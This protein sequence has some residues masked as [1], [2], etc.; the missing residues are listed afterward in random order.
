MIISDV[1]LRQINI[2][3]PLL[4]Y[5]SLYWA[6]EWILHFNSFYNFNNKDFYWKTPLR[7]NWDKYDISW[8]YKIKIVLPSM[9]WDFYKLY[10][11]WWYLIKVANFY[12][13]NISDLHV[14]IIYWKFA[15]CCVCP[16]LE[17]IELIEKNL[18][19]FEYITNYVIP[20]LYLQK[21][22]E[23][24]DQKWIWG[25]YSHDDKWLYEELK[26]KIW[27]DIDEKYLKTIL[28]KG[29]VNK[30]QPC[31]CWSWIGFKK[32]HNSIF[33]LLKQHLTYFVFP[34]FS[35][36]NPFSTSNTLP[37]AS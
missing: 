30:K 25:E 18:S 28:S 8:S 2:E 15:D 12:N 17:R 4:K 23:I 24:F 1:D 35:P 7:F 9:K 34:S 20:F 37:Q 21:W 32:C 3:F 29:D 11:I 6:L 19:I 27:C 13:K 31:I 33:N 5:N 16:P 22:Y 14:N 26:E 36:E 10:E